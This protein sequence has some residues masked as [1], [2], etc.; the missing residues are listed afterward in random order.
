VPSSHIGLV[1]DIVVK[2]R[3][4]VDEFYG[5]GKAV[6]ILIRRTLIEGGDEENKQRAKAFAAPIQKMFKDPI[7]DRDIGTQVL[8]EVSLQ[9]FTF[10]NYRC[11]D[12]IQ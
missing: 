10:L 8:A 6:D 7:D 5:N 2:Q 9:M 4:R 1:H 11:T 3:C 12:G